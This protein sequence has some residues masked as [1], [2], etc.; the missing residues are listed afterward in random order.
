IAEP[1]SLSRSMTW[2]CNGGVPST[3]T[4]ENQKQ[5]TYTYDLMW[6]M[7]NIQFPDGGEITTSYNISSI[8][9]NITVSQLIDSSSHW[10]T[11]ETN[12]DGL[13]RVV[14]S[15]STDPNSTNSNGNRLVNTTYNAL[16]QVGSVTN[17]YFT[18]GDSTYGV[19]YYTY[20][21]L[22][23]LRTAQLP[24]NNVLTYTYTNRAV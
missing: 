18:S 5:T 17:P 24:D 21:A 19:T 1:L 10:V 7:S 12:L 11:T 6:R 8:P 3:A 22:G 23:R 2:D 13:G 9:P 15:A 14:Q 16:G 20:D 4:D